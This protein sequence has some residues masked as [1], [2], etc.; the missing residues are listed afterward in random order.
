MP[1][2]LTLWL[3][4]GEKDDPYVDVCQRAP[5]NDARMSCDIGMILYYTEL[6][7]KSVLPCD[8]LPLIR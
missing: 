7:K 3:D 4:L 6:T 5:T 8:P 2:L 1:R